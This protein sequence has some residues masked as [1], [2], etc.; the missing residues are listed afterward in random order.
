MSGSE[1]G[2]RLWFIGPFPPPLNGQSNY[3]VAMRGHLSSQACLNVCDTGAGNIEKLWRSLSIFT[4]LLFGA[5]AKDKA[6]LSLPGQKGAWLFLPVA[7]A[8]R[9]R[10]IDHFVHHHSF[11]PINQFPS[12]S[13]KILIRIGGAGQAHILLSPVMAEKLK[14]LYLERR[15]SAGVRTLSNAFLFGPKLGAQKRPNRPITIGHMSVLTREKGAYYLLELFEVL[16]ERVPDLRMVIAGPTDDEQLRLAIE[17]MS[18][19]YSD[20][21]EYRGALAGEAKETFY[22]DIDVFALPT[23]LI[24]EA[25]PLVMLEAYGQGVDVVA[26]LTGCIS[27][28]L[29]MKD[30]VLTLDL[31]RDSE[32]IVRMAERADWESIRSD[33]IAFAHSV[34]EIAAAE[35]E[36]LFPEL[37]DGICPA[38]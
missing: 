1:A 22:N 27:D 37:L 6:Y 18:L 13:L 12:R 17:A 33:C 20:D 25:E 21:F 36:N 2:G 19:K 35:A 3:N 11:R 15:P 14:S 34:H 4:R 26:C 23:T 10:G 30:A 9:I 32:M 5:R 8:L 31:I 38:T 24:D 7:L 28:R 29:R 16:H